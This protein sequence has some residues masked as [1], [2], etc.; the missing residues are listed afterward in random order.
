MIL[1][2]VVSLV[3]LDDKQVGRVRFC[4]DGDTMLVEESSGGTST[5]NK[6]RDRPRPR[7]PIERVL[8]QE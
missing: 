6:N 1:V 8:V 7:R 4:R 5:V 2:V 3:V